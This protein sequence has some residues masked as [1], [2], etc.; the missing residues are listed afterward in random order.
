M[1]PSVWQLSQYQTAKYAKLLLGILIQY[2][3]RSRPG[4]TF[5]LMSI[6]YWDLPKK[7][8]NAVSCSNSEIGSA[9]AL[10][11]LALPKPLMPVWLLVSWWW[12]QWI[13][14]ELRIIRLNL[15]LS[16]S[17]HPISP[18]E[19]CVVTDLDSAFTNSWLIGKESFSM[20]T[21]KMSL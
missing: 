7:G 1:F 4:G 6:H 11:I 21:T 3:S 10:P 15:E 12:L 8:D 2:C 18:S 19:L 13:S 9:S 5:C 17:N 20:G 14:G 16:E